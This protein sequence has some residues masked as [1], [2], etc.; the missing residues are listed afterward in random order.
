MNSFHTHTQ[1][2]DE[3]KMVSITVVHP[4]ILLL[5]YGISASTNVS[6]LPVA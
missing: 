1:Q 6:K 2:L 5:D 3:I 4:N